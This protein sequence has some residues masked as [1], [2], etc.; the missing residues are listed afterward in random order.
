MND[1]TSTEI[2][3]ISTLFEA[4]ESEDETK[5]LKILNSIIE[6]AIENEQGAEL[7]FE[8]FEEKDLKIGDSLKEWII[9]K[10]NS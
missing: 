1:K 3:Q 9:N 4:I 2:C 6:I 5:I 7:V 8:V 10:F